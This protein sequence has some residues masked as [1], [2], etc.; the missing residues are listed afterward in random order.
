[1]D[2]RNLTEIHELNLSYLLLVQK[3]LISNRDQAIV[4][5]KI[6]AEMADL[7]IDLSNAQIIKLARVNQLICHLGHQS[8][9]QVKVL[10]SE[11]RSP[12]LAPLHAS[13]LMASTAPSKAAH[14]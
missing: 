14:V 10:V 12:E 2:N 7:L 4:R 8:A 13:L 9:E 6:D 3:L 11:K 5:L 1:M